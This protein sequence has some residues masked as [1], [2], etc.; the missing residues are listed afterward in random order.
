MEEHITNLDSKAESVG[1]SE[2]EANERRL[3]FADLWMSLNAKESLIRQK[4]KIK[5]IRD[6]DLN[7][8]FF[9]ACLAIRRRRNQLVAILVDDLWVEEVDQIKNEVIKHFSNIYLEEGGVR[10][11]LEGVLFNKISDVDQRE[12]VSRFSIEEVE[13]IVQSFDGNKSPSPDGYNFKFIHMFWSLIK[14]EVWG[15]VNEFF[16]S[17]KLPLSFS[18]YFVALIPK[19]RNPQSLNEYLGRSFF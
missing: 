8:L 15:M 13:D 16:E 18:L 1:L 12:L 17:G 10:P 6:G 7:T 9:H 3:K 2:V 4:S 5:W 11:Q 14:E 19:V